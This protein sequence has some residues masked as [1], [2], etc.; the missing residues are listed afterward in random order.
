MVSWLVRLVRARR[1][2]RNP[3]R[4][5]T[6]RLE[7]VLLA[8]L[9]VAFAVGTPFAATAV[10]G[11]MHARAHQEQRAQLATERRVAAVVER[12]IEPNS[13][14][15]GDNILVAA[16]WTAPDG[17]RVTANVFGPTGIAPGDA[18][19]VWVT[20]DG[21]VAN[22]PLLNSQVAGQGVLAEAGSAIAGVLLLGVAWATTRMVLDRRRLKS[23]EAEW[24]EADPLTHPKTQ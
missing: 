1:L 14:D 16:R 20:L 21:Q 24:Q 19:P 10:G 9:I 23:W 5:A 4:R 6:D 11:W 2:D 3:L 13:G 7:T 12:L 17:D 15:L 22:P 18:L 8:V